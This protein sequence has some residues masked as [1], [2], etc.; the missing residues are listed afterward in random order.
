MDAKNFEQFR[1][2]M[3][4]AYLS[5]R[6]KRQA[7]H[8]AFEFGDMGLHVYWE[9]MKWLPPVLKFILKVNCLLERGYRNSLD[10][11]IAN[12]DVLLKNLPKSF[13]G[14]KILQLTDLHIDGMLDSG[15]KLSAI[16]KN[17]E[18]DLCVITGDFRFLTYGDCSEVMKQM[19]RIVSNL[20]V[21]HGV[22]G[23]LG[24]HD[25]VEMVPDLERVGIKMLLNEAIII[26]KGQHTF[27]IA[28]VDDE[29]F[30]Q[31]AN[32]EK[33]I[34]PIMSCATKLL[35]AHSPDMISKA[36][37][38]G[39]DYYLCGHTHGG[40]ICLPGGIP[41]VKQTK[42]RGKYVSG[43]WD[44]NGMKGYTSAGA[45]TSSLSVRFFCQPEITVHRFI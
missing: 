4:D 34:L 42:Y 10:F 26:K 7:E 28:G 44:F 32:I 21:K 36:A 14:F 31:S 9:N 25:F 30:Y 2:R 16:L 11:K 8:V 3:G 19:E 13:K 18:C 5:M 35:L 27:G 12:Q 29:W 37:L 33:A 15:K 43:P 1:I 6:L 23:I 39:F 20:H 40:Q 45:G 24:N 38:V 41:V 22:I 17:I